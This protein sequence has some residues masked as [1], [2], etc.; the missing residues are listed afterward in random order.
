LEKKKWKKS[1]FYF[2]ILFL[3]SQQTGILEN[4]RHVVWCECVS[5]CTNYDA[6]IAVVLA[7][8]KKNTKKKGIAAMQHDNISQPNGGHRSETTRFHGAGCM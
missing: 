5:V 3:V 7:Y 4:Q 8:Y 1:S 2:S 6:L